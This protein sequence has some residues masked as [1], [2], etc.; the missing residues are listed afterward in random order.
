MFQNNSN[1]PPKSPS[2]LTLVFKPKCNNDLHKC[3][4]TAD[5]ATMNVII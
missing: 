2:Q 4:R 3:T 5:D 1:P